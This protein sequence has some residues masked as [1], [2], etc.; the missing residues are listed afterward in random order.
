MRHGQAGGGN[1][2]AGDMQQHAT[3]GARVTP[4]GRTVGGAAGGGPGGYAINEGHAIEV[5]TV[6]RRQLADKRRLPGRHKTATRLQGGQATEGGVD[7][8]RLVYA[9]RVRHQHNF[10]AVDLAG[11]E[12]GHGHIQPVTAV[13]VL[14]VG[15]QI[16]QPPHLA[17]PS[18]PQAVAIGMV[19]HIQA[20]G[21][22]KQ[23]LVQLEPVVITPAH[24]NQAVGAV[25]GK[26]KRY[27]VL[28]QPGGKRVRG[29]CAG[30]WCAGMWCA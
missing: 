4:A 27:I 28:A 2:V 13:M 10:V 24:K 5:A 17:A 15:Q 23:T 11:G 21:P 12:A 9:V 19:L 18:H 30:S 22:V 25:R 20:H 14:T 16:V 6:V 1:A 26:R 3:A 29:R 7:K 8:Q